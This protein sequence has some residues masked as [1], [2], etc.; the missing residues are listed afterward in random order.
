MV[1]I[2]KIGHC[3]FLLGHEVNKSISKEE[4]LLNKGLKYCTNILTRQGNMELFVLNSEIAFRNVQMNNI[5]AEKHA[6]AVA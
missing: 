6:T 1:T 2:L 4:K 3:F 5:S